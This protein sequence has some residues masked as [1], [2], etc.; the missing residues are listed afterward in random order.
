LDALESYT[1]QLLAKI[2][3]FNI[4]LLFIDLFNEMP[5]GSSC[6]K[7]SMLVAGHLKNLALRAQINKGQDF[8]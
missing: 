2:H 7:K 8:I 4:Q 5:M 3:I 1:L 6:G